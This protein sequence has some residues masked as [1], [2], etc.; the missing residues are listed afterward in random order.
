MYLKEN[1][2]INQVLHGDCL[3]VLKTIPDESV[4]SIVTDP[5]Y[6]LGTKEPTG[7]DIERYIKGERLDTGGDF[8]GK[9]WDI[10][11][12]AVWRECFRVLKPGG[13]VL[14]FAGTRT[15]D[16]MSIGLRAAGFQNRDTFA[17]VFGVPILQWV[18]CMSEDTEILT[19][20]GWAK[21]TDVLEGAEAVCFDLTDGSISF[22][23]ITGQYVY[24]YDGDVYHVQGSHTDHIVTPEHRCV[25]YDDD[26]NF[27]FRLAKD[28]GY[29]ARVPVIED[30]CGMLEGLSGQAQE[31]E[32]C[33]FDVFEGLSSET[34]IGEQEGKGAEGSRAVQGQNQA[35]VYGVRQGFLQVPSL[36]QKG[37]ETLLLPVV[38]EQGE[39]EGASEACTQGDSV[40][41]TGR[42]CSV[43]EGHDGEQQ[44]VMAG[45]SDVPEPA[46]ELRFGE[47]REVS[48][49]VSEYGSEGWVRG[50]TPLSGGQGN[51]AGPDKDRVCSSHR[52]QPN[53]QS[54][55]ELD[56]IRNESRPQAVRASRVTRPDM[57]RVSREHYK[58]RVWCVTVP[59]GAFV[60][61][62]NGKIFVTGNSQGFPKSMNIGKTLAKMKAEGNPD[63][64]DEL[65]K[66]WEGYGTALKPAW[67]PILVFRKPMDGTVVSQVLL[68]ETGALNIDGCRVAY[69]SEA[70]KEQALPTSMPKKNKSQVGFRRLDKSQ[71]DPKDHQSPLGRYPANLLLTHSPECKQ[72]GTTKVDAPVINRFDSGA[73]PFGG[74]AGESYTTVQMG[75]ENG[76][77]EVPMYE[78]VEGCPI[79]LLNEQSGESKSNVRRGGEGDHLDPSQENWR[80]KRAEG[81]YEDAGGASRFFQNFPGTEVPTAPFFYT[82]KPSKSE[83]TL[84]GQ[85]DNNHV[86]KKPVRLMRWL[87]RLV[88]QPGQIVLDPYCGSGTT[89]VAATEEDRN[90]IGIELDEHYHGIASK[91]AGIVF[92]REEKRRT[93]KSTFDLFMGLDG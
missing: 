39:G 2:Y 6:G 90:F 16:I 46:R 82:A 22:G 9:E 71:E 65:I 13:Y 50:G 10:P 92:E 68:T 28:V 29:E 45:W 36:G 60:A 73:K 83:T 4:D 89:C 33:S 3:D 23:P 27:V 47:V 15:Q 38:C 54:T 14:A 12:V 64:T 66:K 69:Q 41:N 52:S 58:G 62:R 34:S 76:Q 51:W 53:Q 79:R 84:D 26:D 35:D 80:F 1:D 18:H 31:G 42:V 7:E 37:Q 44:P 17:N 5:P 25:I 57:V 61:R 11:P 74:A 8:M 78:C 59:T 48:P 21:H 91:R 40:Q 30:L 56:V 32:A 49:R 72:V 20:N 55:G 87:V 67:E 63:I 77:E 75:D 24:D 86:T 43:V 19:S 85:V 81:G 93:A 88:S 70:D